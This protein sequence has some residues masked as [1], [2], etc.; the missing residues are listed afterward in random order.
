MLPA[1]SQCWYCWISGGKKACRRSYLYRIPSSQ[2]QPPRSP[3]RTGPSKSV[4]A[5]LDLKSEAHC[6]RRFFYSSLPQHP[7]CHQQRR[8]AGY[9][10]C[11]FRTPHGSAW[12]RRRRTSIRTFPHPWCPTHCK[13]SPSPARAACIQLHHFHSISLLD[14]SVELAVQEDDI[15]PPG[16]SGKRR[17]PAVQGWV[18]G[19]HWRCANARHRTL[20]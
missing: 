11:A 4:L 8:T 12:V 17:L 18:Q 3:A 19:G 5:A 20:I 14:R 2:Q 13:C 15:A 9:S 1:A 6:F 16:Q 7:L 10:G